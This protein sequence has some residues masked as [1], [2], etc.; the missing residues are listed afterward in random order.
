MSAKMVKVRVVWVIIYPG[1]MDGE[2]IT[3]DLRAVWSTRRAARKALKE[4]K[5]SNGADR[6]YVIRKF[7]A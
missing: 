6:D 7:T 3:N 5:G 4:R 2:F 1:G